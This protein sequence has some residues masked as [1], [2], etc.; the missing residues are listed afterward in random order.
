MKVDTEDYSKD[1]IGVWKATIWSS[2]LFPNRVESVFFELVGDWPILF[3]F[4]SGLEIE[5][6]EID[7]VSA[8]CL[9]GGV[10]I[11]LAYRS[12]AFPPL[13]DV[14]GG[15]RT[16]QDYFSHWISRAEFSSAHGSAFVRSVPIGRVGGK[17]T[18]ILYQRVE[19][20]AWSECVP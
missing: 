4:Q 19:P 6:I 16:S 2:E 17:D 15:E 14:D 7:Y 1:Y 18:K 5:G 11:E 13:D 12:D 10:A 8:L 3:W 9:K 20:L